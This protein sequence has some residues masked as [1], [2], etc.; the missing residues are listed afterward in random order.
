MERQALNVTRMR[1]LGATVVPVTAGQATLKEAINEAMRDWV[2][3]VRTTHYILGTRSRLASL[4]DDGARFSPRDRR[5]RR[6]GRFSSR[7]SGCRT[8]WSPAWAAGATRSGCFI[9]SSRTR[10]VRMVGVEAGGEGIVS[11]QARGAVPGRAARR[12]ARARKTW[13]WRTR[14]GRSS[15]RIRSPPGSI[16]RRWGRSIA[17]CATRAG[18]NTITRPTTRRSKAFQTLSRME[19]IIPALESAHAIAHVMKVAPEMDGRSSS[20]ISPGAGTRTWRRRR[21]GCS[22]E[23]LRRKLGSDTGKTVC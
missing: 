21:K 8:C 5:S 9:R 10:S 17:C 6:A 4:P 16:T 3:N 15:S 11:G 23:H 19:G 12:V 14:T 13:C 18:C 2:T 7:R 20:R 1:F 22:K